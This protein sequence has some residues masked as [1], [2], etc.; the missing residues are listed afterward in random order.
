MKRYEHFNRSGYNCLLAK[1]ANNEWYG[2]IG[3]NETHPFYKQKY[4]NINYIGIFS[5][6]N[7]PEFFKI[8]NLILKNLW[9][10]GFSTD[11][12][13]KEK[14]LAKLQFIA[15]SIDNVIGNL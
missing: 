12:F 4:Q 9:W 5:Y 15:D 10:M 8:E 2:Y 6:Q 1:A 3:F 13:S 11:P 7:V 14:T